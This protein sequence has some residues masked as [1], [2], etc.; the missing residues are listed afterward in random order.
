M[1]KH[2]LKRDLLLTIV[3]KIAE[4]SFGEKLWKSFAK[5]NLNKSTL[6]T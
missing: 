3:A 2:D 4:V 5:K 6:I 1:S